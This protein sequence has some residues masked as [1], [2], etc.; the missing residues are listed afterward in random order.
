MHAARAL[1]LLLLLAPSAGAATFSYEI[2]RPNVIWHPSLAIDA[3]GDAHLTCYFIDSYGNPGVGYSSRHQ[4]A[5][6]NELVAPLIVYSTA[7]ALDP[8][9]HPGVAYYTS[10]NAQ[11]FLAERSGGGWTSVPV[12]AVSDQGGTMSVAYD[13]GGVPH[14]AYP[15]RGKLKHAWR[16]SGTW[17]TEVI[18]PALGSDTY[19]GTSIGVDPL[20]RIGVSYHRGTTLVLARRGAQGWVL[21]TVPGAVAYVGT[22]LAFDSQG[23][24]RFTYSE[25]SGLRLASETSNGFVTESIDPNGGVASLAIDAAGDPHVAY[26]DGPGG[27][28]IDSRRAAGVWTKDVVDDRFRSG[29]EIAMALDPSGRTEI[30]YTFKG[31]T[32]GDL[33]F[34]LAAAP[35]GVGDMTAS[36]EF[37][38][39]APNPGRALVLAFEL[40]IACD[41]SFAV[42]DARGRLLATRPAQ[43]FEAGRNA[44]RWE[45]S[46]QAGTY[47]LRLTTSTGE[48]VVQ[49]WTRL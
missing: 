19:P 42:Y 27:R 1:A 25:S 11:P 44:A 45:P 28:A 22:S 31:Y 13:A 15:W 33:R 14:V 10:V 48:R 47:F 20:G 49:R 12:D 34:A 43:R 8:S 23:F 46:L 16:E 18:D 37:A 35:V 7:L 30:A 3:G 5:W 36:L 32:G 21:Q 40:P 17:S 26:Y 24:A 4:G 9:G 39:P 29:Q 6:T 2:I 41:V 38:P